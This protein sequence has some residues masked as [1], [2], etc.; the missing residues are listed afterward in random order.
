[1]PPEEEAAAEAAAA[2]E[3]E[4]DIEEEAQ[5]ARQRAVESYLVLATMHPMVAQVLLRP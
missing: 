5:R 4:T 1:V 3:D 2:L